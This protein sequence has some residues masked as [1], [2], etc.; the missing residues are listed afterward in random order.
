ME[1]DGGL[2]ADEVVGGVRIALRCL[3]LTTFQP[4]DKGGVVRDVGVVDACMD[5][6]K[7]EEDGVLVKD[8]GGAVVDSES[9]D[10]GG[11]CGASSL[12]LRTTWWAPSCRPSLLARVTSM[13]SAATW[14]TVL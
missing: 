5:G 10:E 6:G 14:F 13:M 4:G 2:V 8:A 7:E 12:E 1:G 9:M 11:D 3:G